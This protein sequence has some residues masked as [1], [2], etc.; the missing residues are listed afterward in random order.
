MDECRFCY[1]DFLKKN[2][3]FFFNYLKHQKY[4]DSFDK[5]DKRVLRKRAFFSLLK[6]KSTTLYYVAG[7][8]T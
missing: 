6:E 1:S 5:N 8:I 4:P 7:Y 2:F 3:F